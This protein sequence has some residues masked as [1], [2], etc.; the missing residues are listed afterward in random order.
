MR[1]LSRRESNKFTPRDVEVSKEQKVE[2]VLSISEDG[3][4]KKNRAYRRGKSRA[5]WKQQERIETNEEW[6]WKKKLTGK[7]GPICDVGRAV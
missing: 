4:E 3:K 7:Y 1:T 6:K 5:K 2:K